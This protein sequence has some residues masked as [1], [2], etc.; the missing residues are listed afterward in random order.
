MFYI[1]LG[2]ETIYLF[3]FIILCYLMML[4]ELYIIYVV[5]YTGFTDFAD[6]LTISKECNLDNLSEKNTLSNLFI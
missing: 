1:Q 2:T 5:R 4:L 6:P 3:I